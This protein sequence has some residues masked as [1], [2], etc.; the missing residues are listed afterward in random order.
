[1]FVGREVLP[2]LAGFVLRVW[3]KIIATLSFW[4]MHIIPYVFARQGR[5]QQATLRAGMTMAGVLD[6]LPSN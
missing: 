2:P 1:M 6:N 5:V 3:L 4:D